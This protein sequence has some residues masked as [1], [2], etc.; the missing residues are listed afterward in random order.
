M[1]LLR[2]MPI[3]HALRISLIQSNFHLQNSG[4]DSPY[5]TPCAV[6][7]MEDSRHRTD[8]KL[9]TTIAVPYHN[10]ILPCWHGMFSPHLTVNVGW[11]ISIF[12]LSI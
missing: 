3:R 11:A 2:R 4:F 5:S 10:L 6:T 1:K 8:N 7:K 9:S 12:Y